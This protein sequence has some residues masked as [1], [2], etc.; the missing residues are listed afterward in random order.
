[1]FISLLLVFVGVDVDVCVCACARQI[2]HDSFCET[3]TSMK[4][5]SASLCP[6]DAKSDVEVRI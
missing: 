2:L 5:N 3:Q 6:R 4:E 1:M